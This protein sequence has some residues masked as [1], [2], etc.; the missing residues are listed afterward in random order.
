MSPR[1][2]SRAAAALAA[3]ALVAALCGC[4][5]PAPRAAA[6]RPP[7]AANTEYRIG[8]ADVLRISVWKNEELSRTVP[9]RPDGTISLPLLNDVRA[10][11]LTPMQLRDVL[12]RQLQ[13]YVSKP[14]ISVI[15]QEVHSYAVS[16]LGEVTRAGRYELKGESTVLDA[17]AYAGG[18]TAF[19]RRSRILILR[20]EGGAV[21]RIAF[22]YDKA[23]SAEGEQVN[24]LVRPGDIIVVP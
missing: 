13:E 20:Q 15:I 22:D 18:T 14:Q 6:E 12:S 10:A 23:T 21:Q 17:I 7:V 2:A 4:A 3:V 11:G 9:V 24:P 8:P 5:Q 19:A 1:D 16:V